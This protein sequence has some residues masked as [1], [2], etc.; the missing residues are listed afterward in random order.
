MRATVGDRVIDAST[1]ATLGYI[2]D[3]SNGAYAAT[4]D[5]TGTGIGALAGGELLAGATAHASFTGNSGGILDRQ[6]QRDDIR[7]GDDALIDVNVANLSEAGAD[8]TDGDAYATSDLKESYG[9]SQIELSAGTTVPLLVQLDADASASAAAVGD[10]SASSDGSGLD[11]RA[12]AYA[13]EVVGID[14]LGSGAGDFVF[15]DNATIDTRAGRSS[16]P[17]LDRCGCGH[18]NRPCRSD[19]RF[20][21]RIAGLQDEQ[22]GAV[23]TRANVLEVGNDGVVTATG[24]TDT[25]ASAQ[26]TTGSAI[27]DADHGQG[28]GLQADDLVVGDNGQV[29]AQAGSQIDVSA[30]TVNGIEAGSGAATATADSE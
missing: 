6:D 22:D 16:D 15:G 10:P 30:T 5:G 28:L 24:H 17:D 14:D 7:V 4:P 8:N 18:R 13:R 9:L 1:G 20:P 27:A 12:A 23:D 11:S 3:A 29:Q 26:T 2:I 19:R 21:T 25:D